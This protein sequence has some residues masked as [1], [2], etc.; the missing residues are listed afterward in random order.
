MSTTNYLR[1]EHRKGIHQIGYLGFQKRGQSICVLYMLTGSRI[2]YRSFRKDCKHLDELPPEAIEVTLEQW[3]SVYNQSYGA[4]GTIYPEFYLA[5]KSN[6]FKYLQNEGAGT[7]TIDSYNSYLGNHI[8]PFMTNKLGL[9]NPKEYKNIHIDKWEQSIAKTFSHASTR[10]RARTAFRRYLKFLKRKGLID[11]IPQIINE[12]EVRDTREKPI[13]CDYLPDYKEVVAYIKKLPRSKF[14]F[15]WTLTFAFGVRIGEALC[16][17]RKDVYDKS[18]LEFISDS[19][20]VVSFLTDKKLAYLFLK[21]DR[22]RKKPARDA[23][24]KLISKGEKEGKTKSGDYF[25]CCSNLEI[26]N[27]IVEL[28][29]NGEHE[30]ELDRNEHNYFR[31]FKEDTSSATFHLWRFH[32]ARRYHI[33]MQTLDFMELPNKIDIIC[34]LHA[35]HSQ[36]TFKKYFQWGLMHKRLEKRAGDKSKKITLIS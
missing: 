6:F 16:V 10:N 13:P 26:A 5:N 18:D 23:V 1:P 27:F 2:Q 3:K 7:E 36:Q 28:I 33:T 22:S 19:R 30:M 20:S 34:E 29:E 9:K 4:V 12:R 35:H 17:E 24:L 25:A 14:R 32:D 21:I 15:L 8:F 11:A 31:H